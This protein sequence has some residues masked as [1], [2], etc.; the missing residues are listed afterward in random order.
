MTLSRKAVYALAAFLSLAQADF[1]AASVDS[2]FRAAVARVLNSI[3]NDFLDGLTA[4]EKREFIRCAQGIMA[5]VPAARKRYVLAAGN[6][7]EQQR[8]FN[9]VAQ[10]NHARLKQQIA[11]QCS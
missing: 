8:R 11:S 4:A 3:R 5:S 2:Q 7:S 9:E 1:A 6:A 10:D